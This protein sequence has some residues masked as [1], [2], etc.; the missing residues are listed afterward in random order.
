[1][2]LGSANEGKQG[3]IYQSQDTFL[4]SQLEAASPGP[5]KEG[6]EANV[7]SNT[8]DYKTPNKTRE[9]QTP[10]K[11]GNQKTS[12]KPQEQAMPMEH[13]P[14]D[15]KLLAHDDKIPSQ[16]QDQKSPSKT[17]QEQKTPSK[18]EQDQKTPQQNPAGPEV[19]QPF[20]IHQA[21]P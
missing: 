20:N 3:S 4:D 12:S 16:T 15:P 14:V 21:Y 11:S 2:G 1:M 7:R 5:T 18:T 17:E 19:G 8:M 9:E 6:Q 13:V 10:S